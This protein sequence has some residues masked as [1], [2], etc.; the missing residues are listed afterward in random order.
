M[1]GIALENGGPASKLDMGILLNRIATQIDTSASTLR[2]AKRKLLLRDGLIFVSLTLISL[3]L[4]GITLLLFRSFELHR[5]NLAVFWSD[6]GRD[7]MQHGHAEQGAVSLRNALSYDPDNR[8]YELLL[9][10]ALRDAGQTEQA[11][12]YFL[13]LWESRP[14]DGFINLQL[15][16]LARAKGT[17]SDA[18]NYYRASIFGDWRGDAPVRRRSIRLELADYLMSLD[19]M[20]AARAELLI[21]A[22]NAP[23]DAQINL[24]FG[25]KFAALG[26]VSDA[27]ASYKKALGEDPH[28]QSAL[29][30]IGRLSFHAGDY[31]AA[32]TYLEVA[33]RQG[34]KDQSQRE[35]MLAMATDAQRLVQL[36]FSRRLPARQRADHLLLGRGIAESRF[37]ACSSQLGATA[38]LSAAMQDLKSRWKTADSIV[39]RTVQQNADAQDTLAD[40]ISDTEVTTSKECGQPAGDDALLLMLASH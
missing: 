7:E 16:R 28:N 34:I 25:E 10:Q 15:A 1:I 27:L 5:D 18:V 36:S 3:V 38:P 40:L 39:R 26:D 21:A 12:N 14:G 9:A 22:G 8:E 33:L 4:Y 17:T 20:E 31:E 6:R 11:K 29:Q 2:A 23:N 32:H 13:N 30:A 19:Q 35:Q 24:T 37:N